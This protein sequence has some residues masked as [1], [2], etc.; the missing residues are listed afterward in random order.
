[1]SDPYDEMYRGGPPRQMPARPRYATPP[2]QGHLVPPGPVHARQPAW[3]AYDAAQSRP[4]RP[5]GLTAAGTFWYV[6]GC[7]PFGAMYMCKVPCKKAL[8]DAGL[9]TMTGAERFWYVLMCIAFGGGYFAKLPV[10]KALSEVHQ[11]AG[12][13]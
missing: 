11:G 1:M 6:L 2:P 8:A 3:D 4:R 12:Y 9:G 10:A 13:R 5:A 7:I